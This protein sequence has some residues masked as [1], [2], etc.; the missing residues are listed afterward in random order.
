MQHKVK[1]AVFLG[2]GLLGVTGITQ[3][4]ELTANVGVTSNYVFRGVTQ[5]DDDPAVQGGIDYIHESGVY[6]GAW[7]SNVDFA[8]DTGFETDL[9]VGYNFKLNENVLFDVGYITYIYHSIAG[10]PDADEIYFGAAFKDVS[11]TYYSGDRDSG[12]D[13]SYIDLKYTMALPSD[14]NLHLHYGRQDDDA[15][16]SDYEDAAIG[17][18]KNIEG[19]DVG[20][21]VTTIDHDN[22]N[23]E[24]DEAFITVTKAFNLM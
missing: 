13:Y 3:A 12:A 14:F 15:P 16:N 2:V 8:N 11:V 22:P 19:F 17:V 18:S 10:D 1:K 4:A 20:I 9:Y 5:T 6:A 7:A 21:T 24:D 23:A